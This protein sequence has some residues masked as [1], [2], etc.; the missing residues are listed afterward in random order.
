MIEFIIGITSRGT[1]MIN[2]AHF[3]Q[4]LQS[5][6]YEFKKEFAHA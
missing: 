3:R 1:K 2:L 5:S 6:L 4:A